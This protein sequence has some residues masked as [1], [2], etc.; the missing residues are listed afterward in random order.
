MENMRKLLHGVGGGV[1]GSGYDY[2]LPFFIKGTGGIWFFLALFWTKNIANEII[3][4]SEKYQVLIV[5]AVVYVGV[6][7]YKCFVFPW[8]IQ[9]GMTASL[10]FIFGYYAKREN[11]FKNLNFAYTLICFIIWLYCY[12]YYGTVIMVNCYIPNIM[13][14]I[15]A[16]CG[17]VVIIF[18]SMMIEKN[19]MIGKMLEHI[20]KMTMIILCVHIFE[21]HTGILLGVQGFLRDQVHVYIHI[22]IL[23]CICSFGIGNIIYVFS[24]K[25]IT[26]VNSRIR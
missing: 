15:G 17:S 24:K 11:I 20:G 8:S 26:R 19:N 14:I 9:N 23:R 21:L 2:E 7:T 4:I 22:F 5:I 12:K 10:F 18:F 3:K 16:L 1:Y 25:Y 13:T 6:Q